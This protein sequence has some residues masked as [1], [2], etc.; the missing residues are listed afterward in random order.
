MISIIVPVYRVEPYLRKCIDSIL[1][2]TYKDLEI[3]LIDDGSPDQ[4]GIICDEYAQKDIRIRVFHTENR[5]LASARNLGLDNARGDYIGFVDADDWIEPDLYEVLIDK[6]QDADISACGFWYEYQNKQRKW[7]YSQETAFSGVEALR[8]LI[9]G[10]LKNTVW[11]KL[12]RKEC[13]AAIRFPEGRVHEDIAT[14]Y[15]ILLK[16]YK[17]VSTPSYL[18]H[19]RQRDDSIAGTRS[20]EHLIDYWDAFYGRYKDLSQAYSNDPGIIEKSL[21]QV[22]FSA[23]STWHWIYGVP[24]FERDYEFLNMVSTFVKETYPP[25]GEKNWSRYLRLS[26]FFVRYVNE[27]SFILA[28]LLHKSYLQR[29]D[30]LNRDED[31]C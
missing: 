12:Y 5:G 7:N 30:Y 13:W 1:E 17:V 25:F 15:R 4:C 21:L 18:Y 6:I 28:H 20:M 23:C 8:A 19:Y 2:Q 29:L 27:V 3:L 10:D 11:S 22:A 14:T 26:I 9:N 31:D 16:E 24:K